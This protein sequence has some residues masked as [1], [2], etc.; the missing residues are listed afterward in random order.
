[1]IQ[2]EE[3]ARKL[4]LGL[5]EAQL[6]RKAVTI[7]VQL[8]SAEV[9]SLVLLGGTWGFRNQLDACGCPGGYPENDDEKKNYYR[10]MQSVDISQEANRQKILDSMGTKVFHNLAM[11]VSVT[12]MEK[13]D[14]PVG[15]F[16]Q[17]LRALPN[18][19]FSS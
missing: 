7:N 9:L 15:V 16:I 10:C 18:L 19:H 3:P 14:T 17:T 8:E 12:D 6:P 1:M 11:R 4:P 13:E 5:F 2:L